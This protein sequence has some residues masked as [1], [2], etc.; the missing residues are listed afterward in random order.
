MFRLLTLVLLEGVTGPLLSVDF[1]GDR[2][3]LSLSNQICDQVFQA[4]Y[5]R[6]FFL[7][8]LV[9]E[10]HN[11]FEKSRKG[12]RIW[13]V[14][15]IRVK[16]VVVGELC[17]EIAELGIEVR[18]CAHLNLPLFDF[19]PPSPI[20]PRELRDSLVDGPVNVSFTE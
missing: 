7:L 3:R 10:S 5:H 9:V 12:T 4:R 13:P 19:C 15:T 11:S 17:V 20:E 1:D 16:A 2:D 18:E 6:C 14:L 8:N